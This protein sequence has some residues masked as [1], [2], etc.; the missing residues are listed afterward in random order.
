[1]G[2]LPL[3]DGL[4]L[5]T[6]QKIGV[7]IKMKSWVDVSPS[8]NKSVCRAT[9]LLVGKPN[10][11]GICFQQPPATLDW[12]SRAESRFRHEITCQTWV[13][14]RRFCGKAVRQSVEELPWTEATGSWP[15]AIDRIIHKSKMSSKSQIHLKDKYSLSKRSK[16][17]RPRS[18]SKQGQG[19]K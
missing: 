13:V 5:R 4:M 18:Q 7:S 6:C 9:H 17:S 16:V 2:K 1:M 12:H 14:N 15:L 3:T 8:H 11:L 19:N 10:Y